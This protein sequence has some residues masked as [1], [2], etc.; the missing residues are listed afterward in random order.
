MQR[1]E[2]ACMILVIICG[3]EMINGAPVAKA[4]ITWGKLW[5]TIWKKGGEILLTG[6]VV[7]GVDAS[8]DAGKE[9]KELVIYSPPVHTSTHPQQ[10]P[11]GD[12]NMGLT[13]SL[14]G[15]LMMGMAIIGACCTWV[16]KAYRKL[17]RGLKE[18]RKEEN[19]LMEDR[20]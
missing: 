7:A 1:K 13:L 4:G 3:A 6:A 12:Y 18:A 16:C 5:K 11:Q 8:L 20:A 14:A 15:G 2:I 17:A 10:S 19:I 9:R